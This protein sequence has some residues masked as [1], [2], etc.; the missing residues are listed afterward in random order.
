VKLCP[1][2]LQEEIARSAD[3]RSTFIGPRC[4]TAD[5]KGDAP[6]VDWRDP[7]LSVSYSASSLGNDIER[8]CRAMLDRLG[9]IYGAF[10]FVRTPAGE[11]VFLEVNP[12]GEWAWLEERLGFPMRDA[13]IQ[14]FYGDIT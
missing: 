3:V 13:S 11:L 9:L 14:S 2:L 8:M 10:D 7:D 6:L 4:F 1:V 5:I 12:T